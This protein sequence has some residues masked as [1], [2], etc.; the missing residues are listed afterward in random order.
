MNRR[1]VFPLL[2]L[3]LAA[4]LAACRRGNERAIVTVATTPDLASTG[5]VQML[6]QRFSAESKVVTTLIVTEEPLIP[7][8][9]R[10]G[11]VDVVL[12]TS[13]SL[14]DELQRA[15]LVRL[16]PT[17]AYNDY[18]LVG[19][20]RDPARAGKAKDAAEAL[21]R[22][23][24]RD[25]AFCSPIDVPELRHREAILWAAS[26][27]NPDDDRRYRTCSGTALDVLKEASRRSAY[28][29]TDRA[30][31][32]RAGKEVSLVPLLERT[33]MLHNDLIVVLARPAT[34][35]HSNAEWFVQ[36]IMSYRGRD[37][38]DR[39]RYDGER[40]FYVQER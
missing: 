26:P 12:T 5:V 34:R 19:P 39:Y 24:R 28:T 2:A 32:E 37:W 21:R 8:L 27:A 18:L 40:R 29:L 25:R 31:F 33:P 20:K 35:P 17:I 11:V 30:T 14:R 38:I 22:I 4:M 3:L 7:D 10:S 23:A 9:V 1:R 13:A 36:W 15:R 16:A 6:A